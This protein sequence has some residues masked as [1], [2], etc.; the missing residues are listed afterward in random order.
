MTE[1][2][3]TEPY[4]RQMP[5]DPAESVTVHMTIK[6]WKQ[7]GAASGFHPLTLSRSAGPTAVM[8]KARSRSQADFHK[9]TPL[10]AL[11]RDPERRLKILVED[12]MFPAF[13]QPRVWCAFG[14]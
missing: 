13:K 9:H 14:Q 12:E 3:G 10:I 5:Y 2:G 11:V 6:G 8:L 1:R 4:G 7:S